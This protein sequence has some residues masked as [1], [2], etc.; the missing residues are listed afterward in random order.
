[1][2]HDFYYKGVDKNESHA[3][4]GCSLSYRESTAFSY[5]TAIA[6]VVPRKGVR[7][8]D[9]RTDAPETGLTLFSRYSMSNTTAKHI[10]CVL[11]ASPFERAAVPLRRGHSYR[12]SPRGVAENFLEDLERLAGQ[13]NTIGNRREFVELLRCRRRVMELAC[14]EWAEPL[15]DRRFRKY[16][17]MDVEKMA[18]ELQERNRKAASKRAAETRALFAKYL[19]KAKASGAD[20]CEFVRVLCDNWYGS[21]KFPFD[22]HQIGLLRKRLDKDAAYVWPEPDHNC[23]RTSKR[24]SV[25]LDEAKV[26]LKLW[27]SGRDMRT[28]KIGLY[29]IVKYEG[30]TIQIGCHKIPRE[31]MLALYE[32]VV[33]EKFPE[34]AE[35]MN[36]ASG[37]GGQVIHVAEKE[38][39]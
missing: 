36:T 18:K 10:S 24:V 37:N 5:S 34:R 2:A 9:V 26:L 14:E 15:R 4:C 16:E 28:M 25:P 3:Y 1:M 27:A 21:E 38:A 12:F 35:K 31:N 19:P 11:S 20:Y 7:A 6:K 29:T 30:G 17:A 32:A 23:I 39:G 33:G 22:A 8:E 13:L